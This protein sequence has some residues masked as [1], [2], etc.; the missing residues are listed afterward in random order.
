MPDFNWSTYFN[1]TLSF[2]QKSKHFKCS[3]DPPINISVFVVYLYGISSNLLWCFKFF[4]RMLLPW[5]L[6]NNIWQFL[7]W[8]IVV[9]ALEL[10]YRESNLVVRNNLKKCLHRTLHK[11]N[12]NTI[13]CPYQKMEIEQQRLR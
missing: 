1:F 10:L 9:A 8:A 2:L 12:F 4:A 13:N 11:I 6:S 7:K 3:C 5:H